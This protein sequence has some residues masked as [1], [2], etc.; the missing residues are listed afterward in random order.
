MW[1]V[2]AN[3]DEEVFDEPFKFD[4]QRDPNEHI[5][6]GG[7]GAHYCLGANLARA[8]LRIIFREMLTRMDDIQMAG[9]PDFLRSNFIQGIKHMPITFTPGEQ[10]APSEAVAVGAAA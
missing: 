5:S 3:R 7:G 10:K 6:F 1:H 4:I 2:S 9:E 8:E